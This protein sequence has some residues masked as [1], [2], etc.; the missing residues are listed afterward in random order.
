[1]DHGDPSER[2]VVRRVARRRRD[3]DPPAGDPHHDRRADAGRG[4]GDPAAAA[5][6]GD[7]RRD[8]A[9]RAVVRRPPDHD[10]AA[11]AARPAP[12]HVRVHGRE[13]WQQPGELPAAPRRPHRACRR[14]VRP[15][16][17]RCRLRFAEPRPSAAEGRQ[18]PLPAQRTAARLR[19]RGDRAGSRPGD[20]ACRADPAAFDLGVVSSGASLV[21]AAV[22]AAAA[23]AWVNVVRP[24]IHDAAE[25]AV[26][27]RLA[28]TRHVADRDVARRPRPT[29][30][31]P[32]SN[33]RCPPLRSVEG[34][35]F[36]T[37][38]EVDVAIGQTGSQGFSVPRRLR[39]S[40]SPTS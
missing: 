30:P 15:A 33:R 26:D 5:R 13:P 22:V 8:V 14:V 32:W 23:L 7:R 20:R 11:A 37:R 12:R 18:R 21:A 4:Q 36:T 9:R 3:R 35:P 34:V 10:V 38:I 31:T 19:D 16:R 29:P 40:R 39:R 24:E 27:D 28:E 17:G 25:R 2:H 6:R 1:M